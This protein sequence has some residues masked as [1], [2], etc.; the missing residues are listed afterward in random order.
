MSE[1][2]Q[3]V[4][5]VT[6]DDLANDTDRDFVRSSLIGRNLAHSQCQQDDAEATMVTIV[7]AKAV[8]LMRTARGKSLFRRKRL[9][10]IYPCQA[11]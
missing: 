7:M 3:L 6:G 11:T 10:I 4:S 8:R 2:T 1:V 9:K 5:Y